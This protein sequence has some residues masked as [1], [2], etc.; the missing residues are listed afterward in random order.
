MLQALPKSNAAG[1]RRQCPGPGEESSLPSC[2]QLCFREDRSL[3]GRGPAV[4]VSGGWLESGTHRKSRRI[5]LECVKGAKLERFGLSVG[6]EREQT[7]W[8]P[9]PGLG[10]PYL[11][12]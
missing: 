10:D 6:K 3:R 11:Y 9:S 5:N 2:V 12:D 1:L 7:G 4:P 8:G